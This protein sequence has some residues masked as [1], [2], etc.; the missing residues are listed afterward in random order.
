MD[1]EDTSDTV[2]FPTDPPHPI[3]LR[4]QQTGPNRWLDRLSKAALDKL[5]RVERSATLER[6]AREDAQ[7]D[8]DLKKWEA[9]ASV[10]AELKAAALVQHRQKL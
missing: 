5:P 7:Y 3:T 9:D 4:S 6:Y 8:I 10:R 1:G 2:A